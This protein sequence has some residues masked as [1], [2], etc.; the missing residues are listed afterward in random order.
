MDA[1]QL[2][3]GAEAV[4]AQLGDADPDV[5]AELTALYFRLETANMIVRFIDGMLDDIVRPGGNRK[6]PRKGRSA[7]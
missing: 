2:F 5:P 4:E 7:G 1:A 3:R 6:P